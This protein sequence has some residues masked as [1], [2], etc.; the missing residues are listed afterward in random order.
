MTI[1]GRQ[2]LDHP[3]LGTAGGSTLHTA[4]ETMFTNISNDGSGRFK[5]YSAV[6]NSAVT[7][8]EH[9][10]GVVFEDLNVYLYILNFH[11]NNFQ[12]L[13]MN[14]GGYPY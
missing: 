2:K 3:A 8:V 4:I 10:F 12:Y 1:L 13:K 14:D 11:N 6:A 5:S 9:N 7:V